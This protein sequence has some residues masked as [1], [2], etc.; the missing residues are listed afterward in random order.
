MKLK[1]RVEA[2]NTMAE[3]VNRIL[4]RDYILSNAYKTLENDDNPKYGN[5]DPF[6][7]Y[8]RFL[9]MKV[10][11]KVPLDMTE[12]GYCDGYAIPINTPI[13]SKFGITKEELFS[14][15][16]TI[17]GIVRSFQ[18]M[19]YITALDRPQ[20]ASAVLDNTVLEEAFQIIG[21]NYYLLPSSIHEFILI[22]EEY[23]SD[24]INLAHHVKE[25]NNS[26]VVDEQEVL[27]NHVY[28]YTHSK[29][30]MDIVF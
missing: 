15:A 20:G 6:I 21:C 9:D 16:K 30:K 12:I 13:M 17:P 1:A 29:R 24:P 10:V 18:G 19:L 23:V 8:D 4:T 14:N 26:D 2:P 27:S 25:I 11:C 3:F 22:P 7:P 5:A 28:K